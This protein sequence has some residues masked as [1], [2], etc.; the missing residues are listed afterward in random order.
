MNIVHVANFYGP[1]SGGVRTFMHALARGYAER[2]HT[3][4][5]IVPGPTDADEVMPHFRRITL[6]GARIAFSGGYRMMTDVDRLTSL[7]SDLQP[8]RLE[9]SDRLTLR[10]L[11]RWAKSVGVPSINV[12]H[13][14]VDGVL[15]AHLKIPGPAARWMADV[16]N[17]GTQEAFD[18]IVATTGFAAEEFE[19]IGAKNIHRI[20]LGTD[21][22]RFHP[23]NYDA[24]TRAGYLE[25]PE[26]KLIV[27][28]SRLSTEKRPDLA[29]DA[30]RV[31]RERKLPVRLVSVGT[32]PA[33]IETA[34]RKRATGLP[35]MF[36]GFVP[37][38]P[39][40]AALMASADV[41]MAPGPIETFGLAALETLA[42]GTPVVGSNTSALKEIVTDEAGAT[43]DP[44]PVALADAVEAVLN[45]P[46]AQRREGAR[47]RAQEFNWD[48]TVSKFLKQ[49]GLSD[50]DV[51]PS[52]AVA[53]TVNEERRGK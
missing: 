1:G 47:A 44:D 15:Q 24:D 25:R 46:E 30:L 34:M 14:R 3:M 31:L 19:R 8:G 21:L 16:H 45:R 32:G 10:K 5:L 50:D 17:R 18:S 22:V 51:Q 6:R 12:A 48:A 29:I 23:R 28:A 41:V 53:P 36:A 20:P 35:V 7:L 42:S 43:A 27:L 9:V 33:R 4:T 2:G 38:F 52:P 37:Q 40:L 13:E 26:E 11:G 39:T 49:H